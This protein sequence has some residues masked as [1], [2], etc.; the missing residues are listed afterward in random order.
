NELRLARNTGDDR[1][2]A[3]VIDVDLGPHAEA[4]RQIDPGLDGEERAGKDAAGIVGLEGVEIGAVSV[5]RLPDRVSGP[6]NEALAVARLG[7]RR[8]SDPIELESAQIR[9]ALEGAIRGL[10]HGVPCA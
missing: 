1:P 6:V 5:R 8:A 7:D 3:R 9:A 2:I 10:D 4:A